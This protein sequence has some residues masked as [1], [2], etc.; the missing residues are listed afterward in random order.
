MKLE[1]DERVRVSLEHSA[2]NWR[3]LVRRQNGEVYESPPFATREK[4]QA[5][6]DE[7]I[8]TIIADGAQVVGNN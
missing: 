3:L 6:A 4:A 8:A 2:N 5:L 7:F 1:L